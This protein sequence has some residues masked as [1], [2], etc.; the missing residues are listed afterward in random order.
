MTLKKQQPDLILDGAIRTLE[1]VLNDL[2][3]LVDPTVDPTPKEA[4]RK[5]SSPKGSSVAEA[6]VIFNAMHST[7]FGRMPYLSIADKMALGRLFT[8]LPDFREIVTA[9][10]EST[11]PWIA[12]Q[13]YAPRFIPAQ[14]EALRKANLPAPEPIYPAKDWK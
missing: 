6:I 13:G 7:R 14:V 1:G 4:T 11:D 12:K 3:S 5:P 10:L 8:D 2:K 9:F